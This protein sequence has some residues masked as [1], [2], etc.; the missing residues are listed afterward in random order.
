MTPVSQKAEIVMGCWGQSA[1]WKKWW[2]GHQH[3]VSAACVVLLVCVTPGVVSGQVVLPAPEDRWVHDFASLIE[4]DAVAT[5]ERFH[6][7][8]YQQTGVAVVLVTMPT[9]DGEPIRSFGI[10]LATE[11]E[12]GH[13]DTDLGIVVVLALEER[14]LD[15]ETG[16]GVEGF[17]PDGR[18]GSII[19]TALPLFSAGDLSAGLLRISAGLVTASAEEFGVTVSGATLVAGQV[20]RRVAG[21]GGMAEGLL[22]LLGL[23][24]MGYLLVRHPSLFFLLLLSGGIGGR[25]GRVGGGFGGGASFGGFSG[26]GFGGGGASRGF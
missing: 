8:L 9:L 2:G 7:D 5:M 22:G 10:R 23:L 21:R 25:S 13:R 18:V 16:Y 20:R 1:D 11:W 19:D 3:V 14:D 12:V 17:L 6:T 24:A 26:G 15:I 4:P